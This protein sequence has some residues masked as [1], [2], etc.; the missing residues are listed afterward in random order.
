MLKPFSY[1]TAQSTFQPLLTA[2]QAY[3]ALEREFLRA[4]TEIWASFRV[5]DVTTRLRSVEAR[6]VG[7][8]W[9]DLIVHTLARGVAVHMTISDFDPVARPA[10]HRGTWASVRRLIAAAELAGP[11]ARLQVVPAMH[12]ARTGVVPRLAVWPMIIARQ[13]RAARWLNRL[14]APERATALREMPGLRPQLVVGRDGRC[15]A[16]LWPLPCLCPATHHQKLA[17]FDRRRLYIGGLDLDERRY[18]TPAHQ[19]EAAQTWHDVQLLMDGPAVAEAQAHLQGFQDLTAGLGEVPKHRWLLRTLSRRRAHNALS[20]GP[21]PVVQDIATAHEHYAR[22]TRRLIYVE[23]QY[24][25]DLHLARYLADLARDNP[26]LGMILILPG[27]PEEVAFRRRPSLDTRFGEFLQARAL[28]ILGRAFGARL[29]VGGAAQPRLPET[30][31]PHDHGRDCLNGAPLV[32]IHAKV[33]IFDETAAIV[34]SANLNGRSLHWDTEAG[35]L[36]TQRRDVQNLRQKVMAHWL[37]DGAGEGFFDSTRAVSEWRRLAYENARRAPQDRAG[38]ILPYDHA[39]AAAH[40][41]E[42][43]LVPGE[44]V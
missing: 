40:A 16:R 41:T 38:F 30:R 23:T 25:R 8:T 26:G 11:Q 12:P 3:P 43:P 21:E 39:A 24:F 35:V 42:V 5:F 34:S 2:E 44:M 28:K 7:K 1:K 32:Y 15:R 6:R 18:D 37:P 22:R 29:F 17:V 31:A 14:P 36:I 4:R 19:Q 27:A 13:R 10:L 20:F 9:F 33:S